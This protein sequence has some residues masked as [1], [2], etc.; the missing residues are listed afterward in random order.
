MSLSEYIKQ[1][2]ELS[3]LDFLTVY[4]VIIVLL[5][6]GRMEWDDVQTL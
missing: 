5:K 1:H 6:E 4:D 3:K 2:E